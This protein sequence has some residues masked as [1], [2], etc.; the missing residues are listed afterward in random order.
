[1]LPVASLGVRCLP[2]HSM[3]NTV[4][5]GKPDNYHHSDR[6]YAI[7]L[8]P[9]SPEELE[10][11]YDWAHLPD[12]QGTPVS[13]RTG[14][15][16]FWRSLQDRCRVLCWERTVGHRSITSPPCSLPS[17]A[18]LQHHQFPP[19]TGSLPSILVL[20]APLSHPACSLPAGPGAPSF[21]VHRTHPCPSEAALMPA[22]PG[23]RCGPCYWSRSPTAGGATGQPHH[24]PGPGPAQSCLGL[25]PPNCF[26][27][28]VPTP[29]LRAPCAP[30]TS[31]PALLFLSTYHWF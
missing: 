17:C 20:L 7:P 1:M 27:M 12:P 29:C 14:F 13:G 28:L 3:S 26:W 11:Q 15:Q 10:I 16:M 31:F 18:L 21:T 8:L 6:E 19:C 24:C 9:S 5:T 23:H 25:Q 4:G 30:L 2:L 22:P